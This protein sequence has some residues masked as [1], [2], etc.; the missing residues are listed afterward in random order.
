MSPFRYQVI[1][2]QSRC[3]AMVLKSLVLVPGFV[4]T[5]SALPDKDF[6]LLW[7]G[8]GGGEC[9]WEQRVGDEGGRK[10]ADSVPGGMGLQGSSP[11]FI[12]VLGS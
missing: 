6:W 12:Y 7:T 2:P 10:R 4:A 8:L 9:R 11:Y 5:F 3:S 1:L